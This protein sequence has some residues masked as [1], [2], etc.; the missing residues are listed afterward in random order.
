[1]ISS[2]RARQYAAKW[3]NLRNEGRVP[4]ASYSAFKLKMNA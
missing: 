2:I 1:M 4:R 3:V